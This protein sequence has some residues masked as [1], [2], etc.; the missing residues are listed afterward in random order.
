MGIFFFS[1]TFSLLSTCYGCSEVPLCNHLRGPPEPDN[2]LWT[3]RRCY[4]PTTQLK[5]LLP[6]SQHFKNF[7][8]SWMAQPLFRLCNFLNYHPDK[9]SSPKKGKIPDIDANQ[10]Y[11]KG[12]GV[13]EDGKKSVVT[14]GRKCTLVKEWLL[15]HLSWTALSW[16]WPKLYH[17]QL[18]ISGRFNK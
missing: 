1:T 13:R 7:W 5:N 17:E 9:H 11:G 2:L 4:K 10:V 12:E 16:T 18:S 6:V 8:N 14:G 15:Q 3:L